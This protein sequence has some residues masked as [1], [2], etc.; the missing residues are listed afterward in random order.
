MTLQLADFNS[1]PHG[2]VGQDRYG[3]VWQVRRLQVMFR[4]GTMT[5]PKPAIFYG[6]AKDAGF[7]PPLLILENFGPL[8]VLVRGDELPV[9][10]HR[11]ARP[12]NMVGMTQF[13]ADYLGLTAETMDGATVWDEQG[14]Q[15]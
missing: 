8:H 4:D 13:L 3:H 10:C 2:T 5:M 15:A 14:V 6:H 12:Y 1:M 7:H 9:K 11:R